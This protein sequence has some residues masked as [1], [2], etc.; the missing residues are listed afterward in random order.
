MPTYTL[1]R[2]RQI[3]GSTEYE[4]TAECDACPREHSGIGGRLRAHRHKVR[5]SKGDAEDSVIRN[6]LNSRFH[7]P[8]DPEGKPREL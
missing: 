8:A 7:P 6:A 2:V 5:L 4:Y 3:A 1:L